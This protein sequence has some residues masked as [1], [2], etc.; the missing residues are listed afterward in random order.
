[1]VI[2]GEAVQDVGP[3]PPGTE[4]ARLKVEL[5]AAVAK[6]ESRVAGMATTKLPSFGG[7]AAIPDPD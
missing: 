7:T 3:V 1:M 5:K 6:S 4:S 2:P